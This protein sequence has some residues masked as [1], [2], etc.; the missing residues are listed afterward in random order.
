M[1]MKIIIMTLTDFVYPKKGERGLARFE[2]SV[3]ALIQLEDYIEKQL[4]RLMTATRNNADDTW[5][6]DR[7][8][9]ENKSWTKNNY[10]HVLSD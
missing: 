4:R 1:I 5:T 9:P 10:L 6:A 8:L 2:D 3:D 7:K